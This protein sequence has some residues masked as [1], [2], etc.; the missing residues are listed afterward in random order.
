[1]STKIL[2][3]LLEPYSLKTSDDYANALK[4]VI[5]HVAMLG[6]WREKFFEHGAFYGGTAL[7]IFYGLDRFSEDLDFSL[8]KPDKKFSI[9]PYCRA[10]Q[11]ELESIG[12]K[13]SVQKKV[14]TKKSFIE[15]A[16][17]KADTIENFINIK[18]PEGFVKILPKTHQLKVRFEVDINPPDTAP[19]EVK[20]LLVPIPFQVRIFTLPVLFAGKVHALLCRSWKNRV[21]GRDYYDFIWYVGKKV[22][23]DLNHLEARMK[24]T[25]HLKPDEKLT[26]SR[27]SFLLKKKFS[28]VDF[29]Q[30]K[31]DVLP[32]VKDPQ[33]LS[34]WSKKFFL[35]LISKVKIDS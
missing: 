5:Q 25:G 2:E 9:E 7:R 15:S 14:K 17:I 33:S 28:E 18:V 32:F 6:L 10:I 24:Q 11:A 30:A 8:L 21:K 19:T 3:Q 31:K 20:T 26:F 1:M 34:L 16:F 4:E 35:G 27:V 13:V 23:L 22:N 29:T 12:L